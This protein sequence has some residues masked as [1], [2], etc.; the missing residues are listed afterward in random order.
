MPAASTIRQRP[1]HKKVS[2]CISGDQIAAGEVRIVFCGWPL[3]EQHW[4]IGTPVILR[5]F[6]MDE[7]LL[8]RAAGMPRICGSEKLNIDSLIESG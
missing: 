8:D 3:Q 4:Q 7:D 5:L 6:A 1:K 2:N